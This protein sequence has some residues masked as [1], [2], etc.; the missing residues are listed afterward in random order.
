MGV[1]HAVTWVYAISQNTN[2]RHLHAIGAY[3]AGRLLER[4]GKTADALACYQG[5]NSALPQ[6]KPSLA[7]LKHLTKE[8]PGPP[9]PLGSLFLKIEG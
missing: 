5:A 2:D 9:S 3:T 6:H 7:R 8:N 1:S 4:S